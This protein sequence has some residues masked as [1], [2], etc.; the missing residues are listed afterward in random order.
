MFGCLACLCS[1]EE[2]N[3]S[4]LPIVRGLSFL[5]CYGR[6]Y[7][8][9]FNH[10]F[11]FPSVSSEKVFQRWQ[12]QTGIMR[13]SEMLKHD[14]HQA[15]IYISL[16]PYTV[17]THR[18]REAAILVFREMHTLCYWTG[19]PFLIKK[20]WFG[21]IYKVH[22]S[23]NLSHVIYYTLLTDK[24]LPKDTFYFGERTACPD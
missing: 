22:C 15:G 20:A 5:L 14:E 2:I 19:A 8:C 4:S 3:L 18:L 16:C 11:C 23:A 24:V 10:Y 9:K 12:F 7:L 17:F 21:P 13:S 1:T 6:F